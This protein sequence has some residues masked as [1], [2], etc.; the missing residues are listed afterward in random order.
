MCLY[1]IQTADAQSVRTRKGGFRT[2]ASVR[3]A[4]DFLSKCRVGGQ[5]KVV[6]ANRHLK[7]ARNAHKGYRR[8][9]DWH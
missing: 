9:A 3:E 7:R 2:F 5:F 6:A 1:F 8:Q 4:E